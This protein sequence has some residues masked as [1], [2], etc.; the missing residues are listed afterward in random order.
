MGMISIIIFIAFNNSDII[1]DFIESADNY[2]ANWG[3]LFLL[4]TAI[5][6]YALLIAGLGIPIILTILIIKN[7]RNDYKNS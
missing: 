3:A 6:K 2:S 1:T 4:I 5:I 7:Y